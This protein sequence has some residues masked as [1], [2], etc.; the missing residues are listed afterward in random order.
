[1]MIASWMIKPQQSSKNEV[2]IFILEYMYS[3]GKWN[4]F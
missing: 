2:Q 4:Y 1:M 3:Y